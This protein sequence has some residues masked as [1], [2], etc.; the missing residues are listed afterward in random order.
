MMEPTLNE[1]AQRAAE[2]SPGWSEAEPWVTVPSRTKARLSG[3]QDHSHETFCRPLKRAHSFSKIANPGL[4]FAC[5]GLNSAAGYAGLLGS[6]TLQFAIQTDRQGIS[7][8]D[9][10][11]GH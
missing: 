4:R 7:C 6:F 1:R 5:P 8:F 11:G 10:R 3:R 9:F 2:F